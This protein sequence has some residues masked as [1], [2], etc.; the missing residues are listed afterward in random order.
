M[1][2]FNPPWCTLPIELSGPG[3]RPARGLRPDAQVRPL[4]YPLL[5]PETDDL[6][7]VHGIV[8]PTRLALFA[9]PLGEPE[10]RVRPRSPDTVH[11]PRAG[12]RH[13]LSLTGQCG[14]G[15]LPTG[16]DCADALGI[17]H[18]RTVE[19]DL[20]EVHLSAHVAQRPDVDTRLPEVDE[21]VGD[22]VA[23][24]HGGIRAGQQDGETGPMGPG[25]P[26]LLSG[27]HPLF[28]VA[29]GAAWRATPSRIPSPAR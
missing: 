9:Q 6:V 7:A 3:G 8:P 29:L 22:T 11:P 16:S 27:D 10:E 2:W 23:L 14:I 1:R 18:P 25:R 19:E 15:D 28:A 4:A 17:R 20:V 26:H 21:K 24:R 5:A 12:P 13:H